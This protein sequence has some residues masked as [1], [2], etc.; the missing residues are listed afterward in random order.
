MSRFISLTLLTNLIP[1]ISCT[2]TKDSADSFMSD[3]GMTY[4]EI[5]LDSYTSS[6]SSATHLHDAINAF[7]TN[8]SERTLD[9]IRQS[10]AVLYQSNITQH[11]VRVHLSQQN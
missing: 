11:N 4:A 3:S 9:D 8:P 7:L 10:C 6:V 2:S 1:T 5:V